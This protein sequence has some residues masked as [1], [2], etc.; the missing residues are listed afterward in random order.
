MKLI[1]AIICPEQL[2]QVRQALIKA[3]ITRITVT[4]CAGRGQAESTEIYRGLEFAPELAPKVRLDIA[5]N[6]DFVQTTID[7]ILTSARRGEGEVGDGKIF[8][9]ELQQCIRIRTGESGG[10]AI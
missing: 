7:A 3:E 10:T 5:C 4:R 8:V 6:D 9:T 2:D 1:T